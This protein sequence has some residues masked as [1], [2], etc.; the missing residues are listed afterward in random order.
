MVPLYWKSVD[1]V[2]KQV[3][4]IPVGENICYESLNESAGVLRDRTSM[5]EVR[6]SMDFS[7]YSINMCLKLQTIANNYPQNLYYY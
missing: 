3:S 7:N 6:S 5:N 2:T 1:L 4:N